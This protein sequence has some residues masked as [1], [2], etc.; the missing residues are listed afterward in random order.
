M[1]ET[2]GSVQALT[3]FESGL[4][5]FR[6]L[7]AAHPDVIDFQSGVAGSHNN[8]GTV[9]SETGRP[10]DAFAAYGAARWPSGG[11]WPTP[12]PTSPTTRASWR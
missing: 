1:R 3:S 5:I 2:G 4:A 6:R 8:I 9:L 11:G 7:A 10:D 12:T